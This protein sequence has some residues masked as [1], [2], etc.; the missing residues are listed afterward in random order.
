MNLLSQ[1]YL[2][3]DGK[4]N[5]ALTDDGKGNWNIRFGNWIVATLGP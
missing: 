4:E 3:I 2:V 1:G 5:E